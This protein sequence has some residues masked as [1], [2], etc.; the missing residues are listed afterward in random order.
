MV[1]VR[2]SRRS[3]GLRWSGLAFVP[4]RQA[5][6]APAAPAPTRASEPRPR[7]AF[8]GPC[9]DL[10]HPEP[11]MSIDADALASQL[12]FAFAG[13]DASERIRA[14]LAD[15]DATPSTWEPA[16]FSTHLFLQGWVEQWAALPLHGRPLEAD[17]TGLRRILSHPPADEAT[18]DFRHQI[19]GEL[20]ASPSLEHELVE[21][22]RELRRL[23]ASLLRPPPEGADEGTA[24]RI[25]ILGSL[26]LILAR[27]DS[28]FGAARSG[29]GRLAELGAARVRTEAY[30]RL[31]D[32]LEH[33]R[34][35]A[36]VQLELRLGGDGKVRELIV[37][38]I[39]EDTKNRYHRTPAERWWSKALLFLRGYRFSDAELVDRWIDAVFVEHA[40]LLPGLLQLIGH[41]EW[42][43]AALAL[44][45][46]ASEH[47]LAVCLPTFTEGEGALDALWNPLLAAQG[48]RPV[49]CT[50]G[51]GL[52]GVTTIVTGP[53][54]GGKTRLLQSV[55]LAQLLAQSGSFV[56]ARAARLR[57]VPYLFCSL[58]QEERYDQSEGRLGTEL[59][60]I[61]QM[62]ERAPPGAL[63]IIDELCSGTNPSEGEE[64]F[65]LVL[66]LFDELE[67]ETFVTTHFLDFAHRLASASES[68]LRLRFLRVQLDEA[69]E[70]TFGFVA[71]VAPT[72]LAARAAARLGVTRD[73]LRSLVRRHRTAD[74]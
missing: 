59:M 1:N 14:L 62:F 45:A 73:E 12:G 36:T 67:P 30:A 15:V 28:G 65:M 56:P 13:G 63:L 23:R 3:T 51:R 49:P 71:G 61:R 64:I 57:A 53:N 21:L 38:R 48:V 10:L 16:C 20:A 27:L 50:L 46:Q 5:A 43:L 19:L 60:R 17:A 26:R 58:V 8:G 55:G 7:R 6:A 69:Q 40:E 11:H 35:R 68:V 47:G 66:A 74:T 29:L 22:H 52:P 2:A 25:Q 37:A 32:L 44:R 72:S 54:S 34:L 33:D 24:R 31:V 9:P 18:R 42:Y 70:P 4:N 39:H 41:V